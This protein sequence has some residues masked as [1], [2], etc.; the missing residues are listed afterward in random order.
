M[1][2]GG[3][4]ACERLAR[5]DPADAGI[6]ER[7]EVAVVAEL[8]VRGDR[9]VAAAGRIA[10]A[11]QVAFVA[12]DAGHRVPA[13]ARPAGAGLVLGAG[14]SV[15]AAGAVGTDGDRTAGLR[16]ADRV[17]ARIRR[18]AG[19]GLSGASAVEARV[20]GGAHALI[21]AGRAVVDRRADAP[22]GVGAAGTDGALG[23]DAVDGWTRR[24]DAGA[25]GVPRRAEVA[26]LAARAV[27]RDRI[28]A[29]ARGRIADTLEVAGAPRL[30]RDRRPAADPREAG[31]L[32]SAEVTVV[33]ERP[34]GRRRIRAQ[35][36]RG[37][38]GTSGVTR[39]RGGAGDDR[40][41]DT[42]APRA[43]LAR[44]AQA[45]IVTAGAVGGAG[46]VAGLRD[47][48]LPLERAGPEDDRHQGR[49]AHFPSVSPDFEGLQ[50]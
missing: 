9:I 16:V 5:A 13:A 32:A 41:C 42:G 40:A 1:A 35:A 44:G 4:H 48:R 17:A 31:V 37:I 3:S 39:E 36:G 30:A 14:V 45:V 47:R 46:A 25:A 38:A 6:G 27:G 15:V 18:L 2:L 50:V 20:A 34:V 22:P 10:R 19:E 21:V 28:A 12:L 8:T 26:V 24:A 29:R 49:A 7:A 33:A 23:L 11:R 43:D